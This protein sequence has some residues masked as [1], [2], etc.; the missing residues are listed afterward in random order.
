MHVW[1]GYAGG[2]AERRARRRP[3][4]VP[5]AAVDARTALVKSRGDVQ[6]MISERLMPG[7]RTFSP[8]KTNKDQRDGTREN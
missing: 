7:G 6:S 1:R 3:Y 8:W 2:V 5:M 4:F